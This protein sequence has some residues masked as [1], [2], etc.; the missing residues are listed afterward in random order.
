MNRPWGLPVFLLPDLLSFF[1]TS[2]SICLQTAHHEIRNVMISSHVHPGH[3][4][5][6]L[7]HLHTILLLI[8][9]LLLSRTNLHLSRFS[10]QITISSANI[11]VHKHS[12]L[13]SSVSHWKQYGHQSWCNPNPTLNPSVTATT[14]L[15]TVLRYPYTSSTTLRYSPSLTQA[16]GVQPMTDGVVGFGAWPDILGLQR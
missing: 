13:I 9:I 8:F 14:H 11:V 12:C 1:C 2:F 6:K 15:L 3:S 5:L 4:Q 16:F 7:H 10:P